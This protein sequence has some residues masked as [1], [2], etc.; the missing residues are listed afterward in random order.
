[1]ELPNGARADTATF[2]VELPASRLALG[3]GDAQSGA[4]NA[5]LADTIVVRTLAADDLPVAGIAVELAVASGGGS[6]EIINDTSDANGDVRAVWTLGAELGAQSLTV[7]A[8]GLSGSPITITATAL[9][10]APVRLEITQQPT[11]GVAGA[12]LAP[13]GSL[14]ACA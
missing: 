2:V 7:V 13:A 1:A 3:A 9:P 12:A 4:V 11:D 10:A 14:T 6:L 8:E 5:P